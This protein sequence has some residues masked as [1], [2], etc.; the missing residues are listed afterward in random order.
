MQ[1]FDFEQYN[2]LVKI[3]NNILQ[4]WEHD[5]KEYSKKDG[6]N[7]LFIKKNQRRIAMF[8]KFGNAASILIENL[9]LSWPKAIRATNTKACTSK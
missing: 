3:I 2:D 6:S 8:Q 5:I 7:E 9:I 4:A 1:E